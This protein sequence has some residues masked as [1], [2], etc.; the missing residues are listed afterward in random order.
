MSASP[1]PRSVYIL[2]DAHA[3]GIELAKRLESSGFHV[4]SVDTVEELSELMMG[5]TPNVV[6]VDASHA[7]DLAAVGAAC[8]EA[9]QH[10]RDK[11]QRFP[12][13]ALAVKDNMQSRLE[14]RRA[15]VD[16][17]LFPPYGVTEVVQQLK[18][19]LAPA[20][21]DIVR[22]LIVEDDRS[23]AL[24]AQ[25]VLNNAGMQAEVE[26]DPLHVLEALESLR[27]DLVL[28]DLHMPDANGAE[29]TALIREHPAFRSTPIVFLSGESD[30][31]ARFDAIDAGG[32]DFLAKPISPKH[33]ITSVRNRVRRMRNMETTVAASDTDVRD[34]AS[35]LYRRD[36][37]L[38]QIRIAL[39]GESEESS[40]A[41]GVLF[42]KINGSSTLR[43][44]IGLAALEKLFLGAARVLT[45]VLG[46]SRPAAGINANAFLVLAKGLDVDALDA[47]ALQ[48]RERLMEQAFDAGG[49]AQR[50]RVSVGV[51][52][53]NSG[54]DN[55]NALFD[56]VE[57]TSHEARSS[58]NGIKRYV[59]PGKAQ[60]HR[61]AAEIE[62]LREAITESGLELVY[63]PIVAVK[64]IVEAQYQTL[65]RMRDA[66]GHLLAAAAILPIA[67][68]G[69]LMVELDRWV[70]TRALDVVRQQRDRKLPVQ[71]FVPQ[72]MTT[73]VAPDQAEWLQSEVARHD[74]SGSSLLLEC[75]VEDALLNP[76]ALV[77]LAEALRTVKVRLC[78]VQYEHGPDANR[79]LE[80]IPLGFVKLAPKYVDGNAPEN[81]RNELRQVIDHAHRLG[82]QVVAPRVEDPQAAATLWMSGI[83]FIQGN[84]VQKVGGTLDFDFKEALF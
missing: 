5:L 46:D 77:T 79:L 44:R 80:S 31:E 14:A 50:L 27:P 49:M 69:N 39:G 10:L 59:S 42:V 72:S 51:C 73:L 19:L 33:L 70:L 75:R 63:Q 7:S 65:V 36:Y 52:P 32:D 53:L 25:S 21:K 45:N 48:V 78:L 11:N 28:M 3:F 17:L 15:G 84:L 37:L 2:S 8:R 67:A 56:T 43:D 16:A 9:Q 12:L 57:R 60:R 22:V 62:H 83:D 64:G 54:F 4:E 24:F 34:D 82:I 18:T 71:L 47:L 81:V 23:Q 74:V 55:A 13:A 6:L 35:G 58:E 66:D 29:L 41:G 20:E 1:S 68:R 40:T 26:Q 76:P 38:D 61:E 30:P